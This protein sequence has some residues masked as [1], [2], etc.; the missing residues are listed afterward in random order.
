MSY[1]DEESMLIA[2]IMR[3]SSLNEIKNKAGRVDHKIFDASRRRMCVNYLKEQASKFKE[4]EKY[5]YFNCCHV[6]GKK[7]ILRFFWNNTTFFDT[8]IYTDFHD[9]SCLG[10][11]YF[12]GKTAL[13]FS[14]QLRSVAL[15]RLARLIKH[16]ERRTSSCVSAV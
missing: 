12:L 5:V 8:G 4:S 14:K 10:Y 16:S 7:S 6:K 1:T 9:L 2:E 11:F 15:L 3:E 13:H